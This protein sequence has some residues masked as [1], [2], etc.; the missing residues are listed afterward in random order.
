MT[1]PAQLL[2][3]DPAVDHVRGPANAHVTIVEYGDFECPACAQAHGA[4][5]VIANHFGSKLRLVFRHF[6]Q[7]EVHPHA[8]LA[9]EASEAAG[10]EGKFWAMHD[11]LFA[12]QKHLG[13][14]HLVEHARTL[15]LDIPRFENEL[16]DHVYL[17]RVQE[18]LAVA[19]RLQVRATPTFFVNGTFV[20]VSFG[21]EHLSQAVDAAIQRG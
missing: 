13:D 6:P 1:T 8:Q 19:E 11:L 3:I 20:D 2:K 14:A 7:R 10:A 4:L 16:R 17:Q 15:Q 9:A 5:H 12:H 18:Q 21:L